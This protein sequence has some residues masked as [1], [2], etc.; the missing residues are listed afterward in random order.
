[1]E[2][3]FLVCAVLG[4]TIMVC[5][6][7]LTVI[8]IGGVDGDLDGGGH[9]GDFH[10]GDMHGGE[11]HS[12]D[13]ATDGSIDSSGD[14][15]G[16]QHAPGHSDG[17]LH[18]HEHGHSS[19]WFFGM[20]SFRTL[21]IAVAFFGMAGMA[22]RSADIPPSATIAIAL[23]C[24]FAAMVAIHKLMQLMLKLN[25]DGTVYI[26]RAIGRPGVVYLPV[27]AANSGVGKIHLNLQNRL[28]EYQATTTSGR[29]PS[30]AKVIVTR[31]VG[32]DTVE[33]EPQTDAA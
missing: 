10:G 22:A 18:T 16:L 20:L 25:S 5:Q 3:M 21:V 14:M 24:G 4:G 8:G 31:I 13:V 7:I 2:M 27:P 9:G 30:G 32:P 26:E 1:M 28:M 12:G 15:H 17:N 19:T 33:V 29:I 11:M 23:A 6:F